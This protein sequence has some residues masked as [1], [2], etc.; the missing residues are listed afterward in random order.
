ML[1]QRED[2]FK[3]L[4][5]WCWKIDFQNDYAKEQHVII[6]IIMIPYSLKAWILCFFLSFSFSFSL[7]PFIFANLEA[8]KC[9]LIVLFV[10]SNKFI[11]INLVHIYLFLFFSAL[12][13][14][15]F[16]H[17]SIGWFVF[18]LGTLFCS[19]YV[20]VRIWN[21][22]LQGTKNWINSDLNK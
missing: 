17:F 7:S 12:S 21:C 16:T 4:I 8:E 2:P 11:L 13:I 22:P 10:L 20:T 3:I 19:Y 18:V 14:L 1:G 9:Y 6:I 15:T 5:N